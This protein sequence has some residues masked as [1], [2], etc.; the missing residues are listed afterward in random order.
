MGSG[1]V[2][3]ACKNTNRKFIGVE[4]DPEIFKLAEKRINE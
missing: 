2:G 1:T 3:V 4:K